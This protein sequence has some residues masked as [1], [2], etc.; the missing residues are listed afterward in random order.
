[1]IKQYFQQAIYE[2]KAHPLLSAISIIGTALAIC[3]IMV[4]VVMQQVKVAPFYPETN[5]DRTLHVKY[6]S[7]QSKGGDGGYSNNG[8]MSMKVGRECFRR[9]TVPE[10]VTIYSY[11]HEM[12]VSVPAT[13]AVTVGVKQTDEQFWKVFPFTFID[14]RPFDEAESEAG[15][16]V[17]VVSESV[18]R[19][20]LGSAQIAGERIRL[21]YTEYTVSGVVRDVSTLASSAYAHV[22]IPYYSTDLVRSDGDLSGSFTAAILARDR[23]D[24]RAIRQETEQ[25]RLHFN[26]ALSESELFYRDQ[27]DDQEVYMERKW[28]NVAPDMKKVKQRRW[29]LFA[30]LLIIPAINLSSMTQSR[31]RQRTNEIGLRRSFGSTRFQVLW[32]ILMENLVLTAWAALAGL[33]ICFMVSYF[34]GESLFSSATIGVSPEIRFSML[35]RPVTFVYAVLFC[36]LFNLLSTGI[37]AWKAC[38][39]SITTSLNSK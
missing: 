29:I 11:P 18:A 39:T 15:I 3:L 30:L 33:I 8:R 7:S 22:W 1:M 27:P 19:E 5:R 35:M 12:L 4:L 31:L 2:L 14:G 13:S 37:P 10:A 38:R 36:L 21:N 32:Q 26:D 25:L 23:S 16:P 24:F 9:L 34:W 17:A 20:L 28:A 6:V